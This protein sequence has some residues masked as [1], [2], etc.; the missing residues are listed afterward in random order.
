MLSELNVIR[1]YFTNKAIIATLINTTVLV[2]NLDSV[3]LNELF[4]VIDN[5][6][7]NYDYQVPKYFMFY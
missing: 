2:K 5:E 1:I 6:I 7:V 3:Q 4:C